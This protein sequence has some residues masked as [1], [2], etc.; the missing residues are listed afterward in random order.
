MELH[1]HQLQD[2][3]KAVSAFLPLLDKHRQ[4]LFYG[5]MGV[6]KTSFITELLKQLGIDNI[7]GS[8]TYSLINVYD[9]DK[10]SVYHLDLYRLKD[11]SELFDIGLI[12]L[13]DSDAYFFIEWPQ[14]VE[15]YV[16]P[17]CLS[18]KLGLNDKLSRRI[19]THV[20]LSE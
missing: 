7:Q 16:D 19:Q 12:E 18:V 11:E 10:G 8:P 6:G 3:P 13:L 2:L 9:S 4:F 14:L 1:I 15:N 17:N 5:E 20:G